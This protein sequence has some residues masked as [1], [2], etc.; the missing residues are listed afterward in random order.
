MT[1]PLRLQLIRIAPGF[2]MPISRFVTMS[3][4]SSV[5]GTW[6]VTAS[7]E[8]RSSRQS[9]QGSA[10]SAAILSALRNGS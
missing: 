9:A 6:I 10:P 7:Q 4:V 3:R 1:I 5:S 2:I 8:R